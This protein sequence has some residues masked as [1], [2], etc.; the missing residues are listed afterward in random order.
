LGVVLQLERVTQ[1]DRY[2]L[3]TKANRF[4]NDAAIGFSKRPDEGKT[5]GNFV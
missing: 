5:R 3:A 4:V 1:V 2:I